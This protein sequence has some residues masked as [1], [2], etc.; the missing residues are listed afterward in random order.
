MPFGYRAGT[1][2]IDV[3]SVALPDYRHGL[4]RQFSAEFVEVAKSLLEAAR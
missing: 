1:V 4:R 2:E 3:Y